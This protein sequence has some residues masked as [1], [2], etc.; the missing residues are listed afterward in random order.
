MP[1]SFP[2]WVRQRV[3][4]DRP[5]LDWVVAHGGGRLDQFLQ[6]KI[7]WVRHCLPSSPDRR[8]V[9]VNLIYQK[10]YFSRW[11]FPLQPSWFM[12]MKQKN[13]FTPTWRWWYPGLFDGEPMHFIVNHWP[14]RRGGE[15]ANAYLR[16]AAADLTRSIV[17][18]IRKVDRWQKWLWW[19][20][21]TTTP[22]TKV[23]RN[24]YKLM[25]IWKNSRRV[26]C[27]TPWVSILK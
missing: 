27:S 4:R 26:S 24:T 22:T 13:A 23:W 25:V 2:N 17:D 18:S 7:T 5:L 19:A 3:F 8:G 1:W 10:K 15:K 20:T 12:I 16:N 6:P 11:R 9:D 21:W 14:S